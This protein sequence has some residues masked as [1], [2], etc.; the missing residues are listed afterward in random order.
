MVEYYRLLKRILECGKIFPRRGGKVDCL[1]MF[2]QRVSLNVSKYVPILGSR[3]LNWKAIVGEY[4]W[5]LGGFTDNKTLVERFGCNY[6]T[7]W[8][9]DFGPIYGHQLR[10]GFGVDQWEQLISGLKNDP[11]SRRH[12]VS[13]WNPADLN[14]QRLP[15]CHYTWQA[16]V[17]G[18]GRLGFIINMRSCDV[19]VGL[20]ANIFGYYVVMRILGKLVNREL[21][22]LVFWLG[23][24]HVYVNQIEACQELLN[25]RGFKSGNVRLEINR[26]FECVEELEVNDFNLTGYEPLSKLEIPVWI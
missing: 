19:P 16:L 21:G 13:L 24:V 18:D 25:R 6:W 20:P 15:C 22:K 14:R 9:D 8:G 26:E 7:P 2:N 17:D 23:D 11:Y 1:T 5:I 10:R 3:R 12:V 4:L